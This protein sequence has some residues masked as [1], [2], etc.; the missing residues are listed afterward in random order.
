LASGTEEDLLEGASQISEFLR[1]EGLKGVTRR[2]AFYMCENGQIPAG[3]LGGRW[4]GS[5]RAI[6]AYLSKLTRQP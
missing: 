2:R 3:K 1:Q 5:R 4:V 6:R